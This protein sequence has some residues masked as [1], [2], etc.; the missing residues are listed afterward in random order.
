MEFLRC[1]LAARPASDR[2][3]LAA[4]TPPSCIRGRHGHVPAMDS[5]LRTR[6][7]IVLAPGPL[8][9][10]SFLEILH[11]EN[12]SICWRILNTQQCANSSQNLSNVCTISRQ[13]CPR[14][15]GPGA[16][17]HRISFPIGANNCAAVGRAREGSC[18]KT[19][20]HSLSHYFTGETVKPNKF[21]ILCYKM[22]MVFIVATLDST[23][24]LSHWRPTL[25]FQR[26]NR[27][28]LSVLYVIFVHSQSLGTTKS[29]SAS[30]NLVPLQ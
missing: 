17:W 21:M 2:P 27:S 8:F 5:L 26:K 14:V 29:H 18:R 22:C 13:L 11:V 6:S 12:K 20:M 9:W 23:N 25:K 10:W 1:G 15:F 30:C 3:R 24:I 7:A 19:L 28:G 4:G 16:T